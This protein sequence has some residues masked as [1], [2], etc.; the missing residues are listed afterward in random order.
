LL[1]DTK[2]TDLSPLENLEYLKVLDEN[3]KPPP[4]DHRR[5]GSPDEKVLSI[6]D[7]T[8]LRRLHQLEHLGLYH[9]QVTDLTPLME[10]KKLKYLDISFTPVKDLSPLRGLDALF[11]LIIVNTE[12]ESLEP[13]TQMAPHPMVVLLDSKIA[14]SEIEAFRNKQ[15]EMWVSIKRLKNQAESDQ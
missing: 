9:T 15:P 10:L 5:W 8:P 6:K 14:A 3:S 11:T 13:L 7:L 1:L 2:V 4:E 12:V